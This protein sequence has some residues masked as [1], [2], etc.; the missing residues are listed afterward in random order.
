MLGSEVLGPDGRN[1]LAILRYSARL[2]A[3]CTSGGGGRQV[4]LNEYKE[5]SNKRADNQVR[6][7]ASFQTHR[8]KHPESLRP[9]RKDPMC[10]EKRTVGCQSDRFHN[11]LH[12]NASAERTAPACWVPRKPNV[13]TS[14]Q[15]LNP[16]VEQVRGWCRASRASSRSRTFFL[17]GDRPGNGWMAIVGRLKG[18][19]EAV[20][21]VPP[22]EC[23]TRIAGLRSAISARAVSHRL[24]ETTQIW[25]FRIGANPEFGGNGSAR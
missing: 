25:H 23:P 14:R 15:C 8:M 4:L 11:C 24:L 6:I 18:K 19:V 22:Y 17:S 13:S 10:S 5:E 21:S 12:G 1:A 3:R 16:L 2:S 9:G 20:M 7:I